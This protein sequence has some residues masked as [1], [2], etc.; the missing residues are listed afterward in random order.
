MMPWVLLTAHTA[1]CNGPVKKEGVER[2]LSRAP[3]GFKL[4]GSST[5]VNFRNENRGPGRLARAMICK[6]A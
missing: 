4:N 5:F 3:Q 2:D 1:V 6:T